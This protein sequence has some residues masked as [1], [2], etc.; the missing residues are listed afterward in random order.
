M[1]EKGEKAKAL[2]LQ[3]YNCA[4]AVVGAF[5][6]ELG[7][8]FDMAVQLVSGIGGGMGRLRQ[9]CG[10]VSGMVFVASAK[11]GYSD[12]KATVEKKEL[13]QE[14]QRIAE[15]FRKENGSIVCAELLAGVK[16]ADNSPIPSARTKDYY[17][18]RP[19]A[20]LAACAAEILEGCTW[21]R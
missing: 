16:D 18:K 19:C 6:E 14:I 5:A 8:D 7:L 12:P 17:Q 13:Y 3:G 1:S 21:I 9:V 15:Q 2:F 10:T 4:Q 11:L 20:E